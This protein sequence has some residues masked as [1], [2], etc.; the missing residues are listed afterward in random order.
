M[1]GRGRSVAL[2]VLNAAHTSFLDILFA[3][4]AETDR[5]VLAIALKS[6]IFVFELQGF[7]FTINIDKKI[8]RK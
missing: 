7:I 5:R 8:D 3:T 4:F 6:D 1:G 2:H